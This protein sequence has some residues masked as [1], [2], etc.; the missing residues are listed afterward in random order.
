MTHA[1][2]LQ[3]P[4]VCP[5]CHLDLVQQGSGLECSSCLTIYPADRGIVDFSEGR[6]Y[7][8]FVDGQGLSQR[9]AAGLE[10]EVLGAR[11]RT[12]FYLERL[13]SEVRGSASV[14]VRILDCGCGNGIAV[15]L[16]NQAGVS[17]W[18]NDSSALRK[19]QW[20]ERVYRSRLSVCD[21]A[22]LP[23]RAGFF[24]A[25]ICSGLLEHVGVVE[26]GEPHYEVKV[27]PGRTAARIELLREL[28][29]V[30]DNAG[31]LWLDFPNGAFPVD[32]WHAG[33]QGIRLHSPW[34]GFLPR[35]GEIRSYFRILA[36]DFEV[37]ALS[38]D[39]RLQFRQVRRHWYGR[40]F[41]PAIERYFRLLSQPWA[42]L[43]RK[44][45]LNPYLVL[46]IRRQA[47]R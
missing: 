9:E 47:Q 46:E 37:K 15:D 35:I 41:A 6:Y 36:P 40:L 12:A 7:D 25:I 21:S 14:P 42:S 18:G 16:L 3:E 22:R 39:G 45:F 26:Q 33:A 28:L 30:L 32:F 43:L 1:P 11:R 5:H 38:P 31:V 44:S 13:H 20:R 10:G 27:L 2:G 8:A 19:W 24:G 34:E 17:A 4:Y 29:R 23:F